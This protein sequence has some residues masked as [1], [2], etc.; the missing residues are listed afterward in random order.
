MHLS[1]E[2]FSSMLVLRWK[3][4]KA[5]LNFCCCYWFLVQKWSIWGNFWRISLG[6]IFGEFSL[7]VNKNFFHQCCTCIFQRRYILSSALYNHEIHLLALLFRSSTVNKIFVHF[8]INW[9]FKSFIN[10]PLFSLTRLQL[11]LKNQSC[12]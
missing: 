5:F 3:G 9:G 12:H 11:F 7:Y 10:M 6:G 1:Q 2:I 4:R 8:I